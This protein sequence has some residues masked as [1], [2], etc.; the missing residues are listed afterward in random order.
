MQGLA[1]PGHVAR[2]YIKDSRDEQ[3]QPAGVDIR[4]GEVMEFLNDGEL[5]ATSKRLPDVRSVRPVNGLYRLQ[6]G[7]YKVR[8]LDVVSVPPDA[9]GICYPR[10]TLLRMGITISCAVWDP[11]YMGRGEALMIVAN[12]HGA[13]IEQG[14]RVAQMVF[15]RLESRPS[16]LYSGSYQGENL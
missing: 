14:A 7:A 12:P 8:F 15:I 1:V 16:S 6:P 5:R 13:V 10:S 2:S 9:V 4:L 11:G 3:V